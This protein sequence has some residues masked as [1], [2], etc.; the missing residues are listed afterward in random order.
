MSRR[1]DRPSG[2]VPG[3][4]LAGALVLPLA[5]CSSEPYQIETAITP[6][7]SKGA[8]KALPLLDPPLSARAHRIAL[9]YG[10]HV[11]KE[12]EVL[13]RAEDFC[14]GGRLL[15][16][17]QDVFW[18]GCSILQPVRVTYICDPPEDGAAE[19]TN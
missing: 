3:L 7:W 16:E 1:T 18:N 4:L 2:T 17:D 5:G 10:T 8:H 12:Q 19:Q 11:N 9:C 14:E 15:L 6:P 13:D